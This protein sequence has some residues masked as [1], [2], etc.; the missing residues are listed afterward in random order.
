MSLDILYSSIFDKLTSKECKKLL[1]T[2]SKWKFEIFNELDLPVYKINNCQCFLIREKSNADIKFSNLLIA[3]DSAIKRRDIASIRRLS[4]HQ[5]I[6]SG[7]TD[8]SIPKYYYKDHTFSY[9][10]VKHCLLKLLSFSLKELDGSINL[11]KEV[12]SRGVLNDVIFEINKHK[13]A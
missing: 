11:N 1:L 7:R 9:L 8:D 4:G 12:Y 3:F 10:E 13:K 6:S 2:M 5:G